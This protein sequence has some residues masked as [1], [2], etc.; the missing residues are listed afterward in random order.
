M[1][2]RT[3]NFLTLNL[4]KST[5]ARGIK[6]G[7]AL[8][9]KIF[10]LA[11][12]FGISSQ[13][14]ALQLGKHRGAAIIG[15]PLNIG[16]QATIGSPD[17]LAAGC[18]DVDVYYADNR[19]EKS[20]VRV[21]SEKSG[22]SP[23]D[24]LIRVGTTVAIDEPVV[25]IYLRTG[26]IQ[27]IEKRY[28]VLADVL[29]E[30]AAGSLAA[31]P[32]QARPP[33]A[34]SQSESSRSPGSVLPNSREA[35]R[36]EQEAQREARK[37]RSSAAKLARDSRQAS[38]PGGSIDSPLG[39]PAEP[40]AARTEKKTA[41]SISKPAALEKPTSRL[42]LEPL[43]LLAERDPTLKPSVELR[44]A[45]TNDPAQRSAAAALWRAI[46]AQPEDILGDS[47]KLKSLE[48]AVSG[49]QVQMKKNELDMQALGGDI[50]QAQTE[51]Y[52]NPLVYGLGFLL[53]LAALGLALTL[54]KR[55]A[56]TKTEGD[57]QPWWRK[58]SGQ[59]VGW[60]DSGQAMK[61]SSE[62]SAYESEIES[63]RS[64][65]GHAASSVSYLDL[66]LSDAD[67]K[68]PSSPAGVGRGEALISPSRSGIHQAAVKSEP[69]VNLRGDFAQ[70]MTSAGRAVKAEELFDVQ[71]QAD[72]FVSLGQKDQ[73]I[74]VLRSH[75][76][77]SEETSALVY[78][79]LLKLYHQLNEKLEF[80][81]FRQEFNAKF[82]A[83]MPEFDA[84]CD[85]AGG[86]G[87]QGYPLALSRIVALWPSAKVLTVIEESMFRE[88]DSQTHTFDLE[89]YRE[90]LLLYAMVKDILHSQS[91]GKGPALP[92]V[93]S[94]INR[95]KRS[96]LGRD[97]A[98]EPDVPG[99]HVSNFPLT[100]VVPLA[101]TPGPGVAGTGLDLDLDLSG[102][103]RLDSD[104]GEFTKPQLP[105]TS[106][107]LGNAIPAAATHRAAVNAAGFT[108]P[109]NSIDF[110]FDQ[111]ASA[112]LV[113]KKRI[114]QPPRN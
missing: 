83:E 16:I 36:I 99:E 59:Q 65:G 84:Y 56:E 27:K 12:L 35:R 41:S 67:S 50:K 9:G 88:P 37:N 95:N 63:P 76:E 86:V 24:V 30:S 23:Q 79:D 32:S 72:F 29:S 98:P 91:A 38:P 17:E 15:Q 64:T 71:Q 7:S 62:P 33:G 1:N 81:A 105:D 61:F 14:Q 10:V 52:A 45:P 22:T 26:C 48:S 73:A 75:I 110:E 87:L 104:E 92:A 21:S 5:P 51:K 49:L 66:D 96:E 85:A 90:L 44:T 100:A 109:E 78:L 25:T 8:C 43:E 34:T 114:G 89:A 55:G 11:L 97:T 69:T 4:F 108:L 40:R 103:G 57:V 80:E 42:R 31:V 47:Q 2:S 74:E 20:R 3:L 6:A 111:P 101:A 19:V 13:S 28:V 102:L 93:P 77:E 58:G 112:E 39:I 18:L 60:A 106:Y 46:A 54:R 82:N 70:S 107:T 68:V 94:R 53:F 113:T